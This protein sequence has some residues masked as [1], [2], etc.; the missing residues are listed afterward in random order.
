MAFLDIL[1]VEEPQKTTNSCEQIVLERQENILLA[2]C[3]YC[4]VGK[5]GLC[6]IEN[7]HAPFRQ[8]LVN[9]PLG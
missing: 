1:S 8:L 6:R 3:S 2:M 9:G 4:M 7:L 5:H